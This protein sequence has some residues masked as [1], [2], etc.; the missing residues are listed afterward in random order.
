[1]EITKIC[2]IH[3]ESF[4]SAR[5]KVCNRAYSLRYRIKNIEK[6][7]AS[8]RAYQK[9]YRENNK[10]KVKEIQKK[11]ALKNRE[12]ILQ[13]RKKYR[14]ENIEKFRQFRLEY[15][16]KFPDKVRDGHKRERDK[17]TDS[18]ISSLIFQGAPND[19]SIL[20]KELIEAKREHLKLS[21]M[22]RKIKRGEND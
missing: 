5:C 8:H 19:I 22:L 6:V 10:D 1:M 21:R 7:R 4:T 9:K 13:Y 15:K 16:K 17:M 14:L 11:S 18:Y 12:K 20:P 3:G 2:K